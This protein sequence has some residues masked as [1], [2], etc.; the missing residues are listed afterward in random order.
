[1]KVP[2]RSFLGRILGGAAALGVSS[3]PAVAYG[4]ELAPTYAPDDL[5]SW[6]TAMK[7]PQKVIYDATSNG[8]ANDGILFARNFMKFS[9][10]KLGTKDSEMSVIVSFRHFAT[11]YGYNDAMWA[12]YPQ[13]ASML[14]ADD[15]KTK[16]GAVRNVPMH[17]DMEG[18][19]GTTL[20]ALYARGARF[21]VCGAATAFIA[22]VLAGP[23][24]DAKAVEAELLANLVPGAR[25][26]PAGVV[27]VQRAQ[28]AGFAYT[29]AG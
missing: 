2:R 19:P 7:G 13:F 21:A 5:D 11:P 25:V 1:M 4:R 29:F 12:K 15:P 22:G 24:G 26:V 16:M 28:K 8:G 9:Q 6:L 3:M 20:P 17:D 14:K 10:D 18:F 23:T 27:V